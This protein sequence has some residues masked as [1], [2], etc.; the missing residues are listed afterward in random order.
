MQVVWTREDDLQ[1]GFFGPPTRHRVRAAL[2]ADGRPAA[3][4]HAVAGLSVRLQTEPGS[5]LRNGLDETIAY[6]AVKFPYAVDHYHVSH[7]V[8][9]QTI[10]VLWW[11]RG[12]T[13]NNT[14]VNEVVLDACAHAAGRDPLDYRQALLLPARS[15][16]YTLEGDP[17]TV[18][19][20]RLARVQRLACEAAGWGR[21]LPAGAG[22]GL[23]S[24]VT[25]TY[26]AQ[27]VEVAP[28]AGGGLRVTRVV[29][30]VDCGRVVNPQ[31]ARAQ[32]EGCVAFALSAALG[33]S[34]TVERG[35]VQQSNFN[36]FPLLR[37][38]QMPAIETVF[39]DSSAAPTGLGEPASHPTWAALSNA[40]F[41][42]NGRRLTKLPFK[43]EA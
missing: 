37:I 16:E 17:E 40:V 33:Q 8:V 12:F 4:D 36:D 39:A 21:P 27:V 10:R 41:N 9:E 3:I 20:G 24:T 34:I 23:A 1:H 6:D 30:A 29:T 5:V 28:R 2:A 7:R 13:P 14:F 42:A 38:D 15:I 25:Q 35:R 11:R 18:D 31:L 32:V 22:R 19:T 26:C 43:L